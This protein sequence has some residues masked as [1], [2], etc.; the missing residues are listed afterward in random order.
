M[1]KVINLIS[2][3]NIGTNRKLASLELPL[4]VQLLKNPKSGRFSVQGASCPPWHT[5]LP[6]SSPRAMSMGVRHYSPGLNLSVM[7]RI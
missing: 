6:L 7:K 3:P 1:G 5:N 2:F 4:S